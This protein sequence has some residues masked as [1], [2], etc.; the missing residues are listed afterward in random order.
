MVAQFN[1]TLPDELPPQN[2]EAEEAILGGI[3][4]DPLAFS[5]CKAEGLE[6]QH[7]SLTAHQ[8][9]FTVF[10][11]LHSEGL[12]TDFMSANSRF[13][14]IGQLDQIGG[15]SKLVQLLDRSVSAVNIDEY[16]RLIIEKW[17][18]REIISK[19]QALTAA[20]YSGQSYHDIRS[21]QSYLDIL[22]EPENLSKP[23]VVDRIL[24][25]A[26]Q[27]KEAAQLA[28]ENQ[29][30]FQQLARELKEAVSHRAIP[31]D[32]DFKL[33]DKQLSELDEDDSL[34]RDL[35]F[36]RLAKQWGVSTKDMR[37]YHTRSLMYRQKPLMYTL[38]QFEQR[39]KGL[40]VD[41]IL[42]GAI[43]RGSVMCAYAP[44]STGKTWLTF[45]ITRCLLEGKPWGPP[46]ELGSSDTLFIPPKPMRVLA[47]LSDQGALQNNRM[48]DLQEYYRLKQEHKDAL[49]IV[50]HWSIANNG[51]LR[52]MIEQHQPDLVV[53]D[54]LTSVSNGSIVKENDVPYASP[55]IYWRRMCE[56]FNCSF[57]VI[58]HANKSGSVT[59]GAAMRGTTAIFNACDEVWKLDPKNPRDPSAG[60]IW[61]IEKSRSRNLAR[62]LLKQNPETYTWYPECELDGEDSFDLSS[63]LQKR[64]VDLLEQTGHCYENEDLA[65]TLNVSP[66]TIRKELGRL[67]SS[68]VIGIRKG[69][70]R[71]AVY[72]AYR[73]DPPDP[74][75][76]EENPDLLLDV[77][78]DCGSV[79]Q[80]DDISLQSSPDNESEQIHD[81]GSVGLLQDEPISQYLLRKLPSTEVESQSGSVDQIDDISLQ[82]SSD[83]QSEQ[84]QDSGSVAIGLDQE[85]G[86]ETDQAKVGDRVAFL[87]MQKEYHGILVALSSGKSPKCRID[88]DGQVYSISP[89]K[90]ISSLQEPARVGFCVWLN[91]QRINYCGLL[92]ARHEDLALVEIVGPFCGQ[93]PSLAGTRPV[94]Q[95]NAPPSAGDKFIFS[96]HDITTRLVEP[97]A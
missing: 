52:K 80:I 45:S 68:G 19:S 81:S 67:S 27:L 73:S 54:S 63:P 26:T 76:Q 50:E 78:K 66:N 46:S 92:L 60:N 70:R 75:I 94:D 31:R 91:F 25:K 89:S 58:H 84:I 17:Q 83:N 4:L 71:R 34:Y 41:W 12:P 90:V 8:K 85:V 38:S 24:E 57:M 9:L 69:D 86:K 16:C 21:I 74:L 23:E 40:S 64:I 20:A 6:S 79:D 47:I 33:L 48:F 28:N 5:R 87:Y 14:T 7:F 55:L 51:Q 22:L 30:P 53:V 61:E 77:E 43:P 56:E 65:H 15:Q 82:S 72:F 62:F 13:S 59:R 42:P 2:I 36:R 29:Q 88:V 3:L 18:R 95:I 44:G 49:A 32:I 1:P 35:Q 96:F 37:T 97:T 11:Q 10:E 93:L 39:C